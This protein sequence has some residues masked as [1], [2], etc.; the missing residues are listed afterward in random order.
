MFHAKYNKILFSFFMAFFM[1]AAMSFSM[2][3][4]HIDGGGWGALISSWLDAWFVSFMV[5]L[6][7]TFLINPI[8]L[9]IVASLLD[10][11]TPPRAHK[12]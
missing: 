2:S 3:V 10:K 4:L 11:P 7:I 1:S 12:N 5:A 8:V 6:P 9:F